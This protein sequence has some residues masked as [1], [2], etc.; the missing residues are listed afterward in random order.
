MSNSLINVDVF[1]ELVGK[2]LDEEMKNAAQ[3]ILDKALQDIE[4]KMRERMASMTIAF[5]KND[6]TID[7]MGQDIRIIVKQAMK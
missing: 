1:N 2:Y 5:I 3:P 7:R 4:N 6:I